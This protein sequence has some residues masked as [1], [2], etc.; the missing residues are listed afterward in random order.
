[1]S[2]LADLYVR[3]RAETSGFTSGLGGALAS[4][5]KFES[6]SGK[7]L[8]GFQN[9]GKAA[10]TAVAIGAIAAGV[11]AIKLATDFDSSMTKVAA[12][13]G[14]SSK[15]MAYLRTAVLN[16]APAVGQSPK[17]LADALYFV[18]SAGFHGATAVDILT[19]SAKAS[20][21]GLGETKVVADA[22]TSAMNAYSASH[23]SARQA[24]DMLTEA[25]V[26]GKV[27]A[28]SLAPAL[29]RVIGVSASLGIGY[30]EMLANIAALTRT[31]MSAGQAATALL[32]VETAL[33]RMQDPTSKQ[34]KAMSEL[35]LTVQ[36]VQDTLRTQGLAATLQL[37]TDKAGGNT[38]ALLDLF[39]NVRALR[40]IM[41]SAGV[42]GAAYHA[43]L[44]KIT[45]A[46]DG[47]GAT[48][49]AF[50]RTQQD[51]GFQVRQVI[52]QLEVWGIKLGD[53]LIPIIRDATTWLGKHRDVLIAVAVVIGTVLVGAITVY[54]AH[55]VAAAAATVAATWPFLLIAAAIAVVVAIVVLLW[56]HWDEIWKWIQH[57]PAYAVLIGILLSIV[58]PFLLIIAAAV[59]LAK[60]WQDVWA[61]IK[62]AVADAW[63]FIRPIFNTI[64]TVVLDFV[65]VVM[66]II[67]GDWSK[68][69][70]DFKKFVKDAF[71]ALV[72]VIS[73]VGGLVLRAVG[74]LAQQ[75][76]SYFEKLPSRMYQLGSDMM[77]FFWNANMAVARGLLGWLS[78]LP[79]G[80]VH[81]LSDLGSML[82]NLGVQAMQALWNA[83]VNGANTILGWLAGLPSLIV[84]TLAGLAQMLFS[85]G[86]NAITGLYH[87]AVNAFNDVLN[88]AENI[89]S[90]IVG[91]IGDLGG[92]LFH[93]GSQVVQGLIDGITSKFNDVVQTLTTLGG[94][95]PSW[96]GPPEKDAVLLYKNGQLIMQGL[97]DGLRSGFRPIESQLGGFSNA[98][99]RGMQPSVYAGVGGLGVATMG[100]P[101]TV[102]TSSGAGQPTII[103]NVNGITDIPALGAEIQREVSWALRTSG[104]V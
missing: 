104:R 12:L 7:A 43:I 30:P 28:D 68:A 25:V 52:S 63:A 62:Q 4:S 96:K 14:A 1:V 89:G 71:D 102:P 31:G 54:I 64:K 34:A 51:F 22:V 87:G 82:F 91:A 2:E 11:A 101:S 3:L 79:A 6:D 21:S 74:L 48:Q 33:V 86:S 16:L 60:N 47:A 32:S 49:R 26:Q 76:V 93:A 57:H 78:G 8:N 55:M 5:Q 38:K 72:K 42:Q 59:A 100:G 27:A 35:G 53:F 65:H 90:K 44:D 39:P 84:N 23:L 73:A 98:I 61:W 46:T 81:A 15:E 103:V 36:Q 9:V 45:H 29:G 70:D 77:T 92:V 58:A 88:F 66:D 18:E 80:I 99:A 75:I 20:A 50:N 94:L 37:I 13:T 17:A 41:G 85:V 67:H 19:M 56:T 10:F 69:W 40:D 83:I 97:M 24:T 95:L